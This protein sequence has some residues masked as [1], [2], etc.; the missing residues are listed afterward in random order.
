MP[1]ARGKG[2]TQSSLGDTVGSSVPG[3]CVLL[4]SLTPDI[5]KKVG[6][7]GGTRSHPLERC[8]LF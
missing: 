4:P 7:K 6:R 1:S 8:G 3:P 2:L 5:W